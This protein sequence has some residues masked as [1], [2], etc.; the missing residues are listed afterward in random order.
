[1]FRKKLTVFI[2][3]VLSISIFLLNCSKDSPT[4]PNSNSSNDLQY[5]GSWSGTTSQSKSISLNVTNSGGKAIVSSVTITMRVSGS[6]WSAT[7]TKFSNGSAEIK[8]GKFDYS[9]SG[10]KVTGTF[11][12]SSSLSGNFSNTSSGPPGYGS[13]SASGTYTASK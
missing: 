10:L 3:V 11:S 8:N 2:F 5:V 12:C 7:E 1:M 4:S 13:R 6:G 9:A